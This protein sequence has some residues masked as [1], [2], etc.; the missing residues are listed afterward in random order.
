[1]LDES[2][3]FKGISPLAVS[4]YLIWEAPLEVPGSNYKLL[5]ING[6]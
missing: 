3:I 1:M 2:S 4:I 5:K 6:S